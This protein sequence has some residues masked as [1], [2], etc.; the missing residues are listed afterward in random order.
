MIDR[1]VD[2]LKLDVQGGE[3]D[4]LRAATRVLGDVLAVHVEVEFIPIYLSQ[5]PFDDVFRF[6]VAAGFDLFDLPLGVERCRYHD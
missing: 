3:L 5:P 2:Y 4:A 6:I 1:Q